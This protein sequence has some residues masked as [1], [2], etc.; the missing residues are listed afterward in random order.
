MTLAS[1]IIVIKSTFVVT[2]AL[3][4][5][6]QKQTST[7]AKFESPF[8]HHKKAQSGVLVPPSTP[9]NHL[10]TKTDGSPHKLGPRTEDGLNTQKKESRRRKKFCPVDDEISLHRH[11]MKAGI[12]DV[13]VLT[14]TVNLRAAKVNHVHVDH[15]NR[16]SVLKF[17]SN[18]YQSHL[19]LRIYSFK[20]TLNQVGMITW[21]DQ[22]RRVHTIMV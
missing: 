21:S 16:C 2:H 14:R 1:V 8:V 15:A 9:T 19:Y 10:A 11:D 7:V 18:S 17:Y 13:K 22:G 6:V 5:Y 20:C 3:V 4:Y 12:S